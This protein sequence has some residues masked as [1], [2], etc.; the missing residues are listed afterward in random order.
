MREFNDNVDKK[1]LEFGDA[2]DKKMDKAIKRF[3]EATKTNKRM[4][5][6]SSAYYIL[7]L[8]VIILSMFFASVIMVNIMRYHDPDLT[9]LIL[10]FVASIIFA[11]GLVLFIHYKF[12]DD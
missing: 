4:S 2:A 8:S 5:M 12:G 11:I 1:A 7:L 9:W 10:G 3:K 6:S